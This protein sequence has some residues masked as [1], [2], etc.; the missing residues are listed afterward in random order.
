[1]DECTVSSHFLY[2]VWPPGHH[3]QSTNIWVKMT[4]IFK[5]FLATL[6]LFSAAVHV[7][8]ARKAFLKFILYSPC[9]ACLTKATKRTQFDVI[10]IK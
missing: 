10:Y 7:F 3:S 6:P 8:N 2:L 4:A 1:M 5:S 9:K